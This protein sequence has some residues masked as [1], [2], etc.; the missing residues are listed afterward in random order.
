ML[1][2]WW[3]AWII[4]TILGNVGGRIY[5]NAETT[6]Q[7]STGAW[8]ITASNVIEIV[9]ALLTI[10]IIRSIMQRQA[11]NAALGIPQSPPPPPDFTMLPPEERAPR[12][13]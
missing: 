6:A 8:V 13:S 4:N 1:G 10:Y 5:D 2:V 3:G 12:L 9:S 11:T 7:L